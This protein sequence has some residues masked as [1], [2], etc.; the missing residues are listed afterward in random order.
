M[1]QAVN[2]SKNFQKLQVFQNLSLD[3]QR[4]EVVALIGPSGSGK[5]TFLR[6]L[7]MMET[8]SSGQ[9][10]YQGAS[11]IPS[12]RDRGDQIGIGTLRR[13]VG[14]VFQHFNL[15]PHMTVLQNVCEGPI[16]VKRMPKAE[17]QA[18]GMHFLGLVG[19]AEK[20]DSYPSKLSG[21]QKQRV[22]IARA[23]AMQPGV[24]LLD[25]VTSALDPE[26]VG[27]VLDVIRTLAREGIT[28]AIVTHEMAF[29]ADVSS[30]VL[31]LDK[32]RIAAEGSPDEIIFNPSDERLSN[33]VS[34]TRN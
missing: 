15:F 30:R 13:N 20:H 27:E 16:S 22:A 11:V 2:L 3:L 8:P 12:F 21:G 25:E 29:A 9:V 33:F 24:L 17:A 1:L 26:L 34:R 7:N 18:L 19:L 23:L 5:S 31:F 14:M 32:G 10:L 28:M 6:C 4:G